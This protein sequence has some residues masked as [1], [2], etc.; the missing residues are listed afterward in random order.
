MDE[1]TRRVGRNEA[2]FRAVNEEIE[3]LDRG[4]AELSDHTLHIVCECAD[5]LCTE[6]LVVSTRVYE[7]VRAES[8]L[9][10]LKPGHEVS[11]VEIVVEETEHYDIV[12]KKG[13]AE[14]VAVES[15]PRR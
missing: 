2:I 13:E 10:L 8:T 14:T 4:L 9:F 6:Q 15:D 11:N 3:G 5:L 7:R 12:R 1:N